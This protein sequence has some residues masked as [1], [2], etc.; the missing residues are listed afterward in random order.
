MWGEQMITCEI[1]Y[2]TKDI[3]I[4]VKACGEIPLQ[5]FSGNSTN[6][7]FIHFSTKYWNLIV[8]VDVK[9]NTII[10]TDL[11]CLKCFFM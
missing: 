6:G 9:Q 5:T 1:F 3:H 10:V 4:Q 8:K 11:R 2:D 7:N